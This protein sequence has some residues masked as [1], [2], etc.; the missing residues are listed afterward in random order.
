M[1]RLDT[2]KNPSGLVEW[3][4][5]NETL[6]QY[7]NLL[8]VGGSVDLEESNDDEERA[9][10]EKIHSLMTQYALDD[11]MRW[12]GMQTN[13]RIVGEMYRSVADRRGAFVQPALFEAFGLT[14]IEAMSCG[15]PTF[16]TRYGG[17][18]ETIEDGVSG[19][20]IDPNHGGDAADK[21]LDFF[22]RCCEDNGYWDTISRGALE[23]VSSHYTWELYAERL[24]RLARIYGFWK[25]FSNIEREEVR[26][27]LEMLYFLAFRP[28][29]EKVAQYVECERE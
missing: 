15:L 14:V 6:R 28:M 18:L 12:L 5:Q 9:Q 16:A 26:R 19:F 8:L 4:G 29:A 1:S 21:M 7:A 17:P 13:K 24:L 10:I 11:E 20:H 3:Y 25:Y 2:I 23:R 27:Y 22:V